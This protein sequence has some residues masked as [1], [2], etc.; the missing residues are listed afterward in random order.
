MKSLPC[1]IGFIFIVFSTRI[2]AQNYNAYEFWKMERDSIYNSLKKRQAKG[3]TLSIPDIE[4]VIKYKARLDDYF[5]KLSDNEKSLYFSN[6]TSWG[7]KPEQ[8]DQFTFRQE[9]EIFVGEKSTFT[10]YII[11]SGFYGYYYGVTAI[12]LFDKNIT[13]EG[14]AAIPLLTAGASVL[15]PLLTIRPES[16]TYNSLK[17]SRHG[18]LVGLIHGAAL[19]LILSGVD[20]TNEKLTVGLSSLGSISMG[21]LGYLL[22]KNLQLTPGDAALYSYYGTLMPLEAIAIASAAEVNDRRIIGLSLLAGGASGYL[23]ANRV[24]KN[25]SF[26]PGDITSTRAFAFLNAM[27]GLGIVSDINSSSSSDHP[28]A[29]ILIPV[30]TTLGGSFIS[31]VWLRDAKLTSQQG[32]NTA[33]AA[34]AGVIMGLGLASLVEQDKYS[35][36]YILPYISGLGSY[37]A[38]VY[39]SKKINRPHYLTIENNNK[40][41]F[42]LMPQNILFNQKLGNKGLAPGKQFLNF[43]VFA[44]SYNF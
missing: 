19:G 8:A 9:P 34:G 4:F 30:A 6:R 27:L 29:N 1:I 2:N 13:N 44:A 42:N 3:D 14:I 24:S 7:K 38:M 35:L 23:L 12:Y 25:F 28:T 31:H 33:L 43:P 18:K 32:R 10:K 16:A 17:L 40:W 37:T 21:C 11:S 41:N 15:I 22:G 5:E 20:N 39:I 36:H 26:T